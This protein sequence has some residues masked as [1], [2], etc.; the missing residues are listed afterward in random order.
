MKIDRI[1][2]GAAALCDYCPA[3]G[4][5]METLRVAGRQERGPLNG[6]AVAIVYGY[7]IL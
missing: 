2:A 5:V 4:I 6:D 7:R 1:A 3:P